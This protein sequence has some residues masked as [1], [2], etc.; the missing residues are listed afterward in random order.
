MARITGVRSLG[1]ADSCIHN[2]D[3]DFIFRRYSGPE[4]LEF[5]RPDALHIYDLQGWFGTHHLQHACRVHQNT[6]KMPRSRHNDD[7]NRSMSSSVNSSPRRS[8][9]L[10]ARVLWLKYLQILINS[11]SVASRSR[12]AGLPTSRLRRHSARAFSK[13]LH[14]NWDVPR[15]PCG[16][17]HSLQ[18]S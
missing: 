9:S 4:K 11:S 1:F 17:E 12:C 10:A 16:L 13:L 15:R 6:P 2:A 5:F 3:G 8:R 18:S 7:L 14:G